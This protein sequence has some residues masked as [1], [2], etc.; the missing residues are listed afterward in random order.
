MKPFHYGLLYAAPQ[1]DRSSYTLKA[2]KLLMPP[3]T[4]LLHTANDEL[5]LGRALETLLPCAQILIV[6][7]G[8]ADATLRVAREYGATIFPAA[9]H[10][11]SKHYMEE[12]RHEWV[13][14][15]APSE[16]LT[17]GLQASLFEWSAAP[18]ATDATFSTFICEQVPEGWCSQ[19]IPETRLVPRN[20]PYWAGRLPGRDP[21]SA[22]LEGQLLRLAFP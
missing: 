10:A 2:P 11:S 21:D 14:C 9:S 20:W 17:E 12:V 1:W 18:A 4:A 6:D 16:S 22:T 3:I 7:H 19:P 13:F 8:S 15:L 5:R